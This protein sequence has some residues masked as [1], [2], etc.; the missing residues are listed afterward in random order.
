PVG[1]GLFGLRFE[2]RPV[3]I[4][5]TL[6]TDVAQST[7]GR[8]FRATD[9]ATL[10]RIYDQIDQLERAPVRVQ[11]YTTYTELFRWPLAVALAALALGSAAACA[12]FA[13]AGPRWGI[14]QELVSA[15]GADVVLALDASLSMMAPDDRPNRLAKMK[16]E[17]RRLLSA[18]TGDRYGLIAFAGR[19]Y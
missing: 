7:G 4:D 12:A 3:E 13:F 6:L 8:Y 1:R 17:A 2:N 19:S 16:Q 10:Q 5:D 14:E 18:P 11:R 15:S 9:A